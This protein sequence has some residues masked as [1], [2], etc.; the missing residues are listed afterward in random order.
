MIVQYP[1]EQKD[2]VAI[3]KWPKYIGIHAQ[4]DYA[5]RENG[6]LDCFC[7]VPGNYG[8]IFKIKELRV[9]FSLL[10][11]SGKQ[12]AEFRIIVHPDFVGSGHGKQIIRKT[13]AIGFKKL[14]LNEINLIVRKNN[15]IAKSLYLDSGFTQQGEIK[16][17]IHG[18]DIDFFVM[19]MCKENSKG[20]CK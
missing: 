2:I 6:W 3:K 4:M 5:I 13:L 1:I 20:V 10:I 9:G 19:K 14:E 15:S 11:H 12:E 17:N 8:F 16:K 18:K 7:G